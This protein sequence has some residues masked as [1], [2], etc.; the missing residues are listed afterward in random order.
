MIIYIFYF[1][2][3]SVDTYQ[4]I[5]KEQKDWWTIRVKQINTWLEHKS[6]KT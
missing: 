6:K 1:F 3:F 4:D 5:C 2:V